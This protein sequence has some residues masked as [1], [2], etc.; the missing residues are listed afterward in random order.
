MITSPV[1]VKGKATQDVFRNANLN[2]TLW[3]PTHT[4]T[5]TGRSSWG[6]LV[7]HTHAHSISPI[8]SVDEFCA[9]N[10]MLA[11]LSLAPGFRLSCH[12]FSTVKCWPA[13]G[14]APALG[15][16]TNRSAPNWPNFIW[17]RN[18][19]PPDESLVKLVK[20]RLMKTLEGGL[21]AELLVCF[22]GFGGIRLQLFTAILKAVD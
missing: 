20:E 7:A 17:A 22:G 4:H 21:A 3:P 15:C 2:W 19:G 16:R 18:A 13:C 1:K 8:K 12:S 10:Y 9:S 5:H 11:A 6:R 14:A